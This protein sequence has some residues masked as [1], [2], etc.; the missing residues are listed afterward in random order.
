[1]P[2]TTYSANT[3]GESVFKRAP[4]ISNG[5]ISASAPDSQARALL[6]RLHSGPYCLRGAPHRDVVELAEIEPPEGSL[7]N[8]R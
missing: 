4:P 8:E 5:Y 6:T 7:T 1:M 3:I 2:R